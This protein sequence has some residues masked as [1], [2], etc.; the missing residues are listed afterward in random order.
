MRVG[1]YARVSTTDKDQDPETQLLSLREFI[2]AQNS[3]PAGRRVRRPGPGHGPPAPDR[4]AAAPGPGVQAQAGPD[5]RVPDGPGLSERAGRGQHP[6]AL[7]GLGD[8]GPPV[9]EADR[10]ASRHRPAGLRAEVGGRPPGA[11]GRHDQPFGG[12]PAPRGRLCHL[13]AALGGPGGGGD[14]PMKRLACHAT[15]RRCS[16]TTVFLSA[17]VGAAFAHA[18]ICRSRS[19]SQ[20]PGSLEALIRHPADELGDFPASSFEGG[21]ENQQG[22]EEDDQDEALPATHV[23]LLLTKDFANCLPSITLDT[24]QVRR[25]NAAPF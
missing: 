18:R 1:L 23:H 3:Q 21:R 14:R 9:G 22:N 5:R 16:T 11:E 17:S 4:V 13:P 6:G 15:D 19:R 24:G 12:S 2:A 20:Q 10:A 7:A 8:A 25:P